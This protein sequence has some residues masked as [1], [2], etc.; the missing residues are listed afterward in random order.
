MLKCRA[1]KLNISLLYVEDDIATNKQFTELFELKIRNVYSAK[2]GAEALEIFNANKIDFIISDFKMP[3]MNGNQL[4]KEVKKINAKIPFILLT[5]F[6]DR[7][8]LIEAIEVG[9][10]KFLKKPVASKKLF[11]LLDEFYEKEEMK[12][13][14][15]VSQV[16]LQYAEN[17]AK[18]SN[19]QVNVHTK[20]ITFSQEAKELFHQPL[21]LE[22]KVTYRDLLQMV[23]EKDKKIFLDFF[24]VL[25]LHCALL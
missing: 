14:V 21:E 6:D 10:D 1:N 8:L 3:K 4:C 7:D 22:K 15:E 24:E 18:L 16:C 12:F 25:S 20:G 11:Q 2:D 19:W 23:I 9:I 17:I 5:A 13:A